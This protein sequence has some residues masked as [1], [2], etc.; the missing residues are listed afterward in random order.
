M[1]PFDFVNSINDKTGNLIERNFDCEKQYTPFI[2]NRAFSQFPDTVMAA[3][4]MNIFP[5]LDKRMQ[6]EFLYN[7]I[8]KRKRFS[9]WPKAEW[10]EEVI[11]MV[12]EYYNVS[13]PRAR[14]YLG[15]MTEE[16]VENLKRKTWKGGVKG[17]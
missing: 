6:Y 5:H 1:N 4:S 13:K 15:L 2:V 12:S 10:D 9:R 16:D 3:N 8:K 17:K 7:S 11:G 14:E